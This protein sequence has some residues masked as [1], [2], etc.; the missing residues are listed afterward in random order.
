MPKNIEN[1]EVSINFFWKDSLE[2]LTNS[3]KIEPLEYIEPFYIKDNCI[4]SNKQGI[5]FKEFV[6]IKDL[7]ITSFGLD[8][9]EVMSN[10]NFLSSSEN[11]KEKNINKLDLNLLKND[12]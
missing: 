8:M 12:F 5:L 4:F 11:N 1:E 7:V 10:N 3:I 6:Y 2:Y 9:L